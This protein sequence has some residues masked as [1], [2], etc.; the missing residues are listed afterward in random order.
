MTEAPREEK[1]QVQSPFNLS[2]I[3]SGLFVVIIA[4]LAFL[5]MRERSAGAKA[6]KDLVG[7]RRLCEQMNDR[8]TVQKAL[9]S[10]LA[11]ESTGRVKPFG[12]TDLVETREVRLDDK[13]LQILEITAA[14]GRR[15][16]FGPGDVIVVSKSPPATKPASRP[17]TATQS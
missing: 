2:L 9:H 12:R 7:M 14:A 8:L 3:V 5:W 15:L 13:K 4:L 1:R 11:A 6:Q 17:S 10:M 16:G